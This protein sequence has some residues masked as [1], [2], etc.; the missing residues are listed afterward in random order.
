MAL[1]KPFKG[2]RIDLDIVPK[3]AGH[4][5]FCIDDHSFW[6]DIEDAEGVIQRIQTSAAVEDLLM[7]WDTQIIFNGGDA[8]SHEP[9]A[10]VGTTVLA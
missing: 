8:G 9:I 6:I 10:L 4:A 5:Y 1:F 7:N 2:N 3:I